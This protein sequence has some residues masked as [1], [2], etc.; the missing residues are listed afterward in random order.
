M[1][2]FGTALAAWLLLSII[3]ALLAGRAA[4]GQPA[5]R[6]LGWGFALLAFGSAA[7]ARR[8][9]PARPA[10]AQED[11]LPAFG[12]D[13]AI[14]CTR[15]A[16]ARSP[17]DYS[18]VAW[19][20]ILKRAWAA[21]D[22]HNLGLMAAGV[23]FYAFL[24][25]VPMLGVLVMGYGL[26][27]DP[28]TVS[29]HMKTIL[30]LVPAAAARLIYE[31]LVNLTSEAAGRKGLGLLAALAVS[32]YGASRAS[33]AL[34]AALNVIYG[35]R[36]GRGFVRGT[37]TSAMLIIG[38][39]VTGIVG[40]LAASTLGIA[41]DLLGDRG[42]MAADALQI[43]TWLIA[44]ALCCFAIAAIYRFGPDRSDARW[45]W[46]SVGSFAATLL[47]LF[48]T[49]GFGFYVARFG[50]YNATYGSL[51]A[52]VV[53]LMWLYIS[54]Y[55]ILVG[56]LI[57]AEAERQTARD[58][59]TGPEKPIGRRGARVADMSAALNI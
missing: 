46:L 24:S 38:A 37:V 2:V 16:T 10:A 43:S 51:G 17:A 11:A 5:R 59:T 20:L 30:D 56:G 14:A 22:E 25:F 9:L 45:Q 49:L 7:A 18:L 48:A 41:R 19:K 32:T 53:L 57:N 33:G 47:W 40:V 42:P 6:F 8:L 34:I 15:G 54:A 36:D 35:E 44:G 52:V 58:S 21:S 31:Q 3:R 55:A 39:V 12:E 28:A 27:A 29:R 26:I 4:D 50:A 13:A 23:A 1:K